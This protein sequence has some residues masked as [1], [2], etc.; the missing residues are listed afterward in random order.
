MSRSHAARC[1]A[2]SMMPAQAFA[3]P[4]LQTVEPFPVLALLAQHQYPWRQR[5]NFFTSP[6]EPPCP[7]DEGFGADAPD[8]CR[9]PRPDQTK[10][11]GEGAR[12]SRLI[13]GPGSRHSAASPFVE[14]GQRAHQV[15]S[16]TLLRPPSLASLKAVKPKLLFCHLRAAFQ[17][18]RYDREGAAAVLGELARMVFGQILNGR[19]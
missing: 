15:I 5:V 4:M 9:Q 6:D 16:P 19:T 11:G 10:E 14:H 7:S 3:Q 8:A 12:K 13:G 17:E 1:G 18:P 2:D